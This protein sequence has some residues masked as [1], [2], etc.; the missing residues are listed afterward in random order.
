MRRPDMHRKRFTLRDVSKSMG[1]RVQI[2][3]EKGKIVR[4]RLGLPGMVGVLC[5]LLTSSF[6]HVQGGPITIEFNDPFPAPYTFVPHANTPNGSKVFYSEDGMTF[7]DRRSGH[8]HLL[9]EDSS[10]LVPDDHLL[11][12]PIPNDTPRSLAPHGRGDAIRMTYDPNHD[13]V[14]DRFN[15]LSVDV[16]SGAVKVHAEIDYS[17]VNGAVYGPLPEG[18][19]WNLVGPGNTG[20]LFVDFSWC[21]E[22]GECLT[23]LVIDNIVFEPAPGIGPTGSCN[24]LTATIVGTTGNDNIHG[25]SGRDI[26]SGLGGNDTIAGYGG[27]DVIC[28]D[29][30]SDTIDGG[31]GNNT[32]IGGTGN[33]TLKGGK[34]TDTL[35]GGGGTDKC[36]G[37]TGTDTATACETR[38]NIP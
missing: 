23:T 13:G 20:L 36:D 8:Y 10:V 22:P 9:P 35:N 31:H 14:L 11:L 17:G 1:V 16:R 21:P 37:G 3:I 18:W 4:K 34:G 7:A 15:L 32:L 28:G 19:T 26:I 33:D 12:P 24:G 6:V 38:T 25:T 27:D 30:G 2:N 29:S 5:L